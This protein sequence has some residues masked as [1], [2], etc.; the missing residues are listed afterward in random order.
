MVIASVPRRRAAVSAAPDRRF[1]P[2]LEGMRAFASIGVLTTHV[3]F[4]TSSATGSFLHRV[5]G[6]FDLWVAVFFAL[7]GFLLWR[8]HAVRARAEDSVAPPWGRYLLHRVVRIMPAYLVLVV[9]ALLLLPE[10]AGANTT[11]WLANLTLTQ[12][13]VPWTL[14]GGLTHMWSLAVE[15]GFYLALPLIW[16]AMSVVRGRLARLR[17]PILLAVG[18]A[19]LFWSFIPWPLAEGVNDQTLPPAFGSWFVVGMLLAELAAGPG[20]MLHRLARR[21]VVTG[22]LALGVFLL[23]TTPIAGPEGLVHPSAGEFAVRTGL[24]AILGYLLL[25]PLVLAAEGT[26]HRVLCHPAVLAIGRWSYSL[27]LWHL[28]V[29]S[30]VFPLLGMPMFGGDMLVV[31]PVTVAVSI[32]VAAIGYSLVEEPCR[33]AL[34][35][36]E[37]RGRRVRAAATAGPALTTA[38]ATNAAD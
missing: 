19:S 8:T 4:Q 26:R 6:R 34:G 21:R 5:W 28:V 7:S 16:T 25:S 38:S 13:Y 20:T 23:T 33:R 9:F 17:I 37:D 27:F 22:V 32:V 18:V 31:W 1:Y 14:T 2:A 3:A 35:R 10:A 30:F 24:G 36:R 29:L 12:I 11:T 15:M